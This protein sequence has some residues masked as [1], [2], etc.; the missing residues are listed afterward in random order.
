MKEITTSLYI[1]IPYCI[2]KCAYCDFF[3]MPQGNI[4]PE[5]YIEALCREI[6]YRFSSLQIKELKTIYIGGGTPSLLSADQFQKIF[7]TIKN[8]TSLLSN[9]EITVEVNPDDVTKKLLESLWQCGVNRLSCG[10][11]SMN[12]AALKKACRR[13]DAATNRKAINLIKE[14]WNGETS[15]DLIS[16]LPG[17]DEKSL[18][19]GLEE[20]VSYNPSHISLYSLT[21]EE[22]TPLGKELEAGKLDYDFDLADKLW[23]RGR[24]FLESKGYKWYEVSNFC[25]EGKECAHNLV[26]WTHGG[27]AGC[28]PAACGTVYNK[29]GSGFRWTNTTDIEKYI[30]YWF[31]QAA[32]LQDLPDGAE[33][34]LP[35]AYEQIDKETSEFEFFMMGLRKLTGISQ[36]DYQEIFGESLPQ[37]F[38]KLFSE[39]EKK[40]LCTRRESPEDSGTY[41]MSREGMLFLNRFN[42][43]LL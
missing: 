31:E 41:A 7:S 43:E 8:N 3:S 10:L 26:Y 17:D 34:A 38:L 32:A 20:V 4:I 11:Q 37:K 29:D 39:W 24:N 13:A 9:S 35:Q 27:Y 30:K 2:S 18:L 16:G 25:R 5:N 21:I 28:G 15:F 23:L 14:Y 6:V 40:G 22:R 12:D 19:G 33:N 42:M 1:H 36:S